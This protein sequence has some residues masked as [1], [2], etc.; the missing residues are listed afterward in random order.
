MELFYSKFPEIA[1][2]ETRC[3]IIMDDKEKLPKG[4]YFLLESYCNDHDCDCCRVFINILHK[5]KILATIGY[6]WKDIEF[7]E[8]WIGDPEL[9]PDVKGPILELTGLHTEYSELLL[10]LFK[11][12]IIPD[13]IFIERLEMHY[14]IFKKQSYK[15]KKITGELMDFDPKLHK[16]ANLCK[17]IGTDI[18][19]INDTTREVFYPIIMAIEE[20]IWRYYLENSSLKDIQVIESLKN[21]RDNIFS[22]KAEFNKL[23]ENIITKLKIVLFLNNY[24]KRDLSLSISSVLKSARLHR[25]MGENREYLDFISRFF[26][27]M[28]K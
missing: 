17:E 24:D 26:N 6:G 11:K 15:R 8:N 7:Y 4:E 1:E 23:E 9:A 21:I 18:E 12:V 20:T 27:Q 10:D 25:S 14:K 13:R 3:I 2:R 16:V 5:N 22:D 19:I 28:K